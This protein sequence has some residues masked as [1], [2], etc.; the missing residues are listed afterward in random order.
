MINSSAPSSTP[1]PGGQRVIRAYFFPRIPT[2]VAA[3][4]PHLRMGKV[5]GMRLKP[6][7]SAHVP[8]HEFGLDVTK[9]KTQ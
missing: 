5:E 4:S 6:R 3:V 1:K 7:T 2:A 9:G 8:A